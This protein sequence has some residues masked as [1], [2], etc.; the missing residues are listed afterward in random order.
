MEEEG[1]QPGQAKK[2]S[3]LKSLLSTMISLAVLIAALVLA[4][5][6]LTYLVGSDFNLDTLL[7]GQKTTRLP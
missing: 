1:A 4:Y 3:K 5:Y 7:T 2:G 6:A